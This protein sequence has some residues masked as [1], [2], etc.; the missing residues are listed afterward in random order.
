MLSGHSILCPA[1]TSQICAG[2]SGKMIAMNPLFLPLSNMAAMALFVVRPM[3][4]HNREESV[5]FLPLTEV[6]A[7]V[8]KAFCRL[9][10]VIR[11][12]NNP[13]YHT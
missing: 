4:T 3:G 13:G 7:E 12:K 9:M 11:Q 10:K 5:F 6:T 2:V 8:K 1:P